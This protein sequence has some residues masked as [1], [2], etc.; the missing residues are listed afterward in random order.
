MLEIRGVSKCFG[1]TVALDE[2]SF[3]LRPGE[4]FGVVGSNGAGNTTLMRI[5]ATG[6][7]RRP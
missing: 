3:E 1:T 2:V 6:P 5:A 4:V 7:A